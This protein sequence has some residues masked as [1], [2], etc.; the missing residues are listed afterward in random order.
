MT[1]LDNLQPQQ[2]QGLGTSAEDSDLND[3]LNDVGLSDT[4]MMP[5][6]PMPQQTMMSAPQLP[7][8]ALQQQQQVMMPQYQMPAVQIVPS[9]PSLVEKIKKNLMENIK[10]VAIVVVLFILF[11]TEGVKELLARNIPFV[12][13]NVSAMHTFSSTVIRGLMA[14]SFFLMATQV[15]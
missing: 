15:V 7:P 10:Y 5:P 3:I 12:V 4:Q 6:P 2:G 13:D 11:N 1:S 9:G 8:Q 14:G